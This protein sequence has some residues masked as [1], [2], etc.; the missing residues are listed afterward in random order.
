MQGVGLVV[1]IFWPI[2]SWDFEEMMVG[3]HRRRGLGTVIPGARVDLPGGFFSYSGSSTVMSGMQSWDCSVPYQPADV[4]T[5]C[6]AAGFPNVYSW[7]DIIAQQPNFSCVSGQIIRLPSG[8]FGCMQKVPGVQIPTVQSSG[9]QGSPSLSWYKFPAVPA[10]TLPVA[11]CDPR[12]S[13]ICVP[14]TT[15]SATTT[16]TSYVPWIIGAA[17]MLLAIL[18][19]VRR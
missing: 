15:G 8:Q 18:M 13:D 4:A 3:Q 19:V 2:R 5:A 1:R 6:K 17:V 14:P 9:T 11:P 12:F 7:Q 10:G 16:T